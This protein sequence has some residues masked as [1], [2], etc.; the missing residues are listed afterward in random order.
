MFFLWVV[1]LHSP[2]VAAHLHNE[3]E[4]NSLFVAL[5]MSGAAFVLTGKPSK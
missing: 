5:A 2:R 1:L 4:W 3:G